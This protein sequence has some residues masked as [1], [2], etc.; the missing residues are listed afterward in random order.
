MYSSWLSALRNSCSRRGV[1]LLSP[2]VRRPGRH[3]PGEH[4]MNV[5]RTS[6]LVA[7][8]FAVTA[9][10]AAQA[11]CDI[12]QGSPFQLNS[13]KIYLNKAQ[14]S[15]GKVDEKVKHLQS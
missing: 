8:A 10:A 1:L 4:V 13:A 2:F 9:E 15:S 6:A 12:N 7:A 3:H 14:S 5:L 11:K